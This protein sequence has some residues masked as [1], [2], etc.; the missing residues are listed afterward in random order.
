MTLDPEFFYYG[1]P[2]LTKINLEK[3]LRP[4]LLTVCQPWQG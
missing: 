3:S 1:L 2:D 4:K